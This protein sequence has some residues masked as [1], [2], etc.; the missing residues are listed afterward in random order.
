VARRPQDASFVGNIVAAMLAFAKQ[1]LAIQTEVPF[2]LRQMDRLLVIGSDRMMAAVKAARRP[3][4]VLASYVQS[5]H[6]GIASIN[7]P[8][9]CM[10][11]EICAQCL[12]R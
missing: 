4:G 6:V 7:S 3:G 10:M 8:M 12:Q 1:E 5:K 11:K 9:Q 2:T